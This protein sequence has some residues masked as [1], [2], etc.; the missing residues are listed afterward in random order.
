M[1]KANGV[2]SKDLSWKYSGQLIEAMGL[3]AISD[4]NM[5]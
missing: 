4:L 3:G 2:I 5:I 1:S